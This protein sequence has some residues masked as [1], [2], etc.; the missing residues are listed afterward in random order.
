MTET[1][2]EDKVSILAELWI[3]Y[4]NDENYQEFFEYNDLGLPLAYAV[5][6]AIVESTEV[7]AKYIEET[8]DLL[9]SALDI[10]E[11]HGFESIDELLDSSEA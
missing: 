6:N 8:F 1:T 2:Y 5:D 3:D 9:L 7:A 10:E 4:R 11:D